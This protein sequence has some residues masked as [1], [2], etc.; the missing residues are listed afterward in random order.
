MP[1]LYHGTSHND[2]LNMIGAQ[3]TGTID[4]TKGSGEFGRG[5]YCHRKKARAW[6]HVINKFANPGMLIIT[7]QDVTY[8]T[9]KIK[10]LSIQQARR[11]RQVVRS[12]ADPNNF[13]VNSD[14]VVGPIE[15]YQRVIQEK[16]ETPSAGT[17][18]NSDQ[19]IR[20]VLP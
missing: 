12:S 8:N 2:A 7:I 16:F 4:V 20:Q 17:V 15:N 10:Q 18:L 13:L 5:F 11:L 1:I 6:T 3:G 14:V 19:T 9:L